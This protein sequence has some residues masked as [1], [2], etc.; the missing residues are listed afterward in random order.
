MAYK[1]AIWLGSAAFLSG[2]HG[3]EPL[4]SRAPHPFPPREG[5]LSSGEA[6]ERS[7]DS[8]LSLP[9][10]KTAA[11]LN[12]QL[13]CRSINPILIMIL[14][15]KC[16]RRHIPILVKRLIRRK[17]MR[18]SDRSSGI[19]IRSM[20]QYRVESTFSRLTQPCQIGLGDNTSE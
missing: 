6:W 9:K 18:F 19:N 5:S 8:K 1:T 7:S 15:R 11:G 3:L 14:L 4:H 2:G 13:N 17:S 10:L 20:T 16:H 12:D